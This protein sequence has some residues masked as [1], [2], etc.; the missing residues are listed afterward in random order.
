YF[1]SLLCGEVL[2]STLGDLLHVLDDSL[3]RGRVAPE[4]V[5][6]E[7]RSTTLD[8]HLGEATSG[9][10]P[11]YLDWLFRQVFPEL[12]VEVQRSSIPRAVRLD[13]VFLGHVALG[14]CALSG[15]TAL[16]TDALV[17]TLTTAFD[18][19]GSKAESVTAEGDTWSREVELRL[20]RDVLP[21]FERRP[22]SLRVVLR[23]LASRTQSKVARSRLGEA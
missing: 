22:L 1:H 2:A 18:T 17:V 10:D 8:Q 20:G 3:W 21:L 15:N 6:R 4:Y 16:P 5:R 23:V 19:R 9:T 11:L 14:V 13:S 12:R 7:L